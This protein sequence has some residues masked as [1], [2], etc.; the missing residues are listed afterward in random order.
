MGIFRRT[1][2][3][4]IN[5]VEVFSYR[6]Q[7]QV[8][9]EGVWPDEC[10]G[11]ACSSRGFLSSRPLPMYTLLGNRA[12]THGL[13]KGLGCN[14]CR[15]AALSLIAHFWQTYAVRKCAKS[16]CHGR[17]HSMDV[18]RVFNMAIIHNIAWLQVSLI[19]SLKESQD[20][21]SLMWH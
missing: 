4:Y 20:L 13:V 7:G 5:Q 21:R 8:I 17:S 18:H 19:N 9:T 16:H 6:L 15:D 14:T 3:A 10:V 11:G 12:S 1:L 2:R